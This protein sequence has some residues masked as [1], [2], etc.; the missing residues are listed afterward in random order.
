MT[1]PTALAATR[2]N[3]AAL[4]AG[5]LASVAGATNATAAPSALRG[6]VRYRERI[7]LPPNAICEISL[8]DVSLADAPSVAIARTTVRGRR[9]PIPYRLPYDSRRIK[10]GRTYALQARI[11]AGGRLLFVTTT[12]HAVFDGRR[13]NTDIDVERVAQSAPDERAPFGA[14]LAEDIGGRGVIDNART[15]IELR[16]SGEAFG[17]GGCNRISGRADVKGAALRFGPMISTR[18]A[19]APALMDQERKFLDALA[20]TRGFRFERDKLALLDEAGGR[21]A[22]LARTS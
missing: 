22:L 18:M 7:A 15:M 6:V 16:A 8:L 17:S 2:R 5:A 20:A 4:V 10:P 14:W 13:L 9:S 19:C 21:L 3:A 1:K 12:R 11:S